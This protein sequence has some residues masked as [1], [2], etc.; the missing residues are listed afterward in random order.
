MRSAPFP[1]DLRN[2]PL[3]IDTD[4]GGDADDALAVAAAARYTSDLKLV[5]TGDESQGRRARFARHLLD[6]MDRPDVATVAGA[7]LSDTPYFV[8]E[9]LVPQDVPAQRT[10]VVAAVREVLDSTDGPVLWVG[11]APLSNLAHVLAEAPEAATRL[12][13]TQMGGALR[14]RNPEIA[15]HNVRLDVPAAHSVLAAVA[16]GQLPTPE[17]IAS[18]VTFTPKIEVTAE[19]ELYQWLAAPDAPPW[20]ALLAA[21]LDAWFTRFHPGSMQHDALTLTAALDLPF[22][23]SDYMGIS[24]DDIGRTTASDEGVRLR[25]SFEAEYDAFM[26]WL[27]KTLTSQPSAAPAHYEGEQS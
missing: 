17:F 14:Y 15:E 19:S 11:M 24:M 6:L 1:E 10:D 8:I 16:A 23:E 18:E 12:R 26:A 4:I 9:H 20:A 7:E 13:V 22:V 3:I 27:T 5:I 21:H 25:W 2:A